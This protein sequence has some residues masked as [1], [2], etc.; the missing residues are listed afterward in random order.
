MVFRVATHLEEISASG[1][2]RV[3]V[4]QI[5]SSAGNHP[6]LC[7]PLA[8]TIN[9]SQFKVICMAIAAVL[10]VVMDIYPFVVVVLCCPIRTSNEIR[11]I[12]ALSNSRERRGGSRGT[13][14][15]NQAN[16]QK[17]SE[18]PF[19]KAMPP[20]A[21]RF[22]LPNGR[23]DMSLQ[24]GHRESDGCFPACFAGAFATDNH[25]D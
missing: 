18:Y 9:I 1:S 11:F 2:N 14:C 12:N 17:Q 10:C 16:G 22:Y 15:Q 21:L 5:I 20:Q 8:R 24:N 23:V 19:H 4:G 25:Y 6:F 7:F 3:A 13:Y